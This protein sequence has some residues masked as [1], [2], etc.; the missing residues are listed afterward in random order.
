MGWSPVE[1]K[2]RYLVAVKVADCKAATYNRATIGAFERRPDL[3]TMSF[4]VDNGMEFNRYRPIECA[5]S[6]EVYFAH[7]YPSWERGRTENTN[8]L[9][10]QFFPRTYDLSRV[11]DEEVEAAVRLWNPRPRKCLDDRTPEEALRDELVALGD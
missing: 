5:L 6:T 4:T 1:H 7:P 9:L 11:T 3:P 10:R 2:R 8:G